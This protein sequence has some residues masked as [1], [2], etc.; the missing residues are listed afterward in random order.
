MM[1]WNI[2]KVRQEGFL[3]KERKV[4][5]TKPGRSIAPCHWQLHNLRKDKDGADIQRSDCRFIQKEPYM[6]GY[7]IGKW[8]IHKIGKNSKKEKSGGIE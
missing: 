5:A 3:G 2:E 4:R 1:Q 6:F 7:R 8:Y